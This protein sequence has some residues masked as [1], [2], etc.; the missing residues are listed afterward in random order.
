MEGGMFT[1]GEVMMS[2]SYAIIY[3][4]QKKLFTSRDQKTT[5][6]TSNSVTYRLLRFLLHIGVLYCVLI[7]SIIYFIEDKGT[8]YKGKSCYG[9][10]LDKKTKQPIMN[11]CKH[12]GLIN[13]GV[14]V[15]DKKDMCNIMGGGGNYD[16]V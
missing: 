15:T 11:V 12:T 13:R 1:K 8:Y 10:V 2:D 6:N 9:Y 5:H 16:F 7:S 14:C 3:T 4:S